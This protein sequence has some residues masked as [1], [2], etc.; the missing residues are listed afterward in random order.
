[1]FESSTWMWLIGGFFSSVTIWFSFALKNPGYYLEHL[2]KRIFNILVWAGCLT[3]GVY[4]I[5]DAYTVMLKN[6]LSLSP[7]AVEIVENT[8][9]TSFIIFLVIA[10]ALCLY[11]LG[12]FV[13]YWL[14][15]SFKKYQ[16]DRE[17]KNT[18]Q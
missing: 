4:T 15:E 12:W 7:G 18:K 5:L 6:R 10:L 14:A 16:E 8:W 2:S 13:A 3:Y 17:S 1:M 9:T 11:F